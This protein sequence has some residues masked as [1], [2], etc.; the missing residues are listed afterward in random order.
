MKLRLVC[1]YRLTSRASQGKTETLLQKIFDKAPMA[2]HLTLHKTELDSIPSCTK[3][4]KSM[5]FK[6]A[7]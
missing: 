6:Q 7:E 1:G 2:E 4:I 5:T 3:Y